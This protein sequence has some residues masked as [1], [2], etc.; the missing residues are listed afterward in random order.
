MASP[1][2]LTEPVKM[3]S[4]ATTTL[5]EL[6]SPI[7]S[8]R[9][10]SLLESRPPLAITNKY[11]TWWNPVQVNTLSVS[12]PN[13]KFCQRSLEL[14]STV[15]GI[16]KANKTEIDL[17]YLKKHHYWFHEQKFIKPEVKIKPLIHHF[18]TP[19]IHIQFHLTR[20]NY[21][22]MAG[23]TFWIKCFQRMTSILHISLPVV[24]LVWPWFDPGTD[25]LGKFQL[26]NASCNLWKQ[27]TKI[28]KIWK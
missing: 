17:T 14:N 5:W 10:A 16:F 2:S 28:M 21:L 3:R 27:K 19:L 26:W 9:L 7:C 25:K 11:I 6:V 20:R 15:K 13:F 23:F 24:T 18:K 8:C 12:N 22:D 1:S 4:T